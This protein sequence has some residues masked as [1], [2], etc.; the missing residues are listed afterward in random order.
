[1]PKHPDDLIVLGNAERDGGRFVRLGRACPANLLLKR[2]CLRPRDD[3]NSHV[4]TEP[5]W[6]VHKDNVPA[7]RSKTITE[8]AVWA[9]LPKLSPPWQR[10]CHYLLQGPVSDEDSSASVRIVAKLLKG[11]LPCLPRSGSCGCGGTRLADLE[12]RDMTVS[13]AAGHR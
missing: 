10:G 9:E 7:T 13:E 2:H 11:E 8:R 6:S 1:M 4:F 3:P 5:D 12:L